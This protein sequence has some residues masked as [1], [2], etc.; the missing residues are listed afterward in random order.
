[1]YGVILVDVGLCDF[2]SPAVGCTLTEERIGHSVVRFAGCRI[3]REGRYHVQFATLVL[4]V[5]P[6]LAEGQITTHR[7]GDGQ[8]RF[9]VIGCIE[10]QVVFDALHGGAIDTQGI[11]QQHLSG[12]V[13]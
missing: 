1:M 3:D 5:E 11:L 9:Y 12:T 7:V 6:F 10:C 2:Q 4:I 8:H 13:A